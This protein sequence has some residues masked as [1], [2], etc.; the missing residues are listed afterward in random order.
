[1]AYQIYSVQ[2]PVRRSD[3]LRNEL[4][5]GSALALLRCILV[6]ALHLPSSV[7]D[8]PDA[9]WCR[10]PK[11]EWWALQGLKKPEYTKPPKGASAALKGR[12]DVSMVGA[13]S[14]WRQ[15]KGRRLLQAEARAYP[16]AVWIQART[17]RPLPLCLSALH[18]TLCPQRTQALTGPLTQEVQGAVGWTDDS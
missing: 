2:F 9:S 4:M 15:H 8:A 17:H 14:S 1:M 12:L 3:K 7:P 11:L 16:A 10:R 5:G 13:H 18:L 6:L